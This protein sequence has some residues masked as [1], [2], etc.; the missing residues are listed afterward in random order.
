MPLFDD[1]G[2]IQNIVRP[3]QQ[4]Q[5]GDVLALAIEQY[6][7]H[8]EGTI[9]RKSKLEGFINMRPVRGT[10]TLT[11]YAIGE[12]GEVKALTPGVAPEA[13][14]VDFSKA[15]ITVDT[16]VYQRAV[17]P[18]LD[19]FQTQY[20]ARK[21][22]GMEH[23]KAIAKFR[24]QSMFIQAAKASLMTGSRFDNGVAGKPKGHN[25]GNVQ[26]LAAAGDALD[27]AKLYSAI[28]DLFIKMEEKDVAPGED[29]IMLAFKP[30]QFYALMES[31]QIINRTY[32][33]SDGTELKDIPVFKA[34]GCPVISTNNLPSTNITNH[35]L[36]N[37][38]NSNAYNGDFSKLVGVA[39]SPRALLGGETIPLTSDV[40]FNKE[41]KVWYVDSHLSYAVTPNRPEFAGSIWLP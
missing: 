30:A 24:D 37:A 1:A 28:G 14:N 31:E 35:V 13:E 16:V 34:W 5:S 39:L 23:G 6:Q 12:T 21:E 11:D 2:V 40:W 7:G 22:I 4:N 17:L 20:D 10:T 15:S 27:P 9:R 3:N 32:V 19:V 41:Y 36:S 26:T 29:D 25:G 38:R 8:V 18:L 33:T